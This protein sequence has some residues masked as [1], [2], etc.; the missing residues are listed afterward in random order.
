MHCHSLHHT[1]A[2]RVRIRFIGEKKRSG[3]VS[4]ALKFV[5]LE[6][7]PISKLNLLE[8]SNT[9]E[10]NSLFGGKNLWVIL[11]REQ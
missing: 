2:L 9:M 10:N 1:F 4:A 7:I 3:S 11:V 5:L 6:T 8:Q